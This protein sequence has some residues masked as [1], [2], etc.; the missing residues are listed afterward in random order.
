MLLMS[1]RGSLYK[2]KRIYSNNMNIISCRGKKIGK[3]STDPDIKQPEFRSS[4]A[5][6]SSFSFQTKEKIQSLGLIFQIIVYRQFHLPAVIQ[7]LAWE[8]RRAKVQGCL[9]SRKETVHKLKSS[10]A[11]GDYL[12]L[13]YHRAGTVTAGKCG[14]QIC[15]ISNS[16]M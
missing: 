11:E 4:H 8:Q 15:L 16:Q 7:N 2:G 12:G 1:F 13:W 14:R 9:L 3:H 10:S 5:D 6:C